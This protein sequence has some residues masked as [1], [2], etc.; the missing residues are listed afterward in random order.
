[1]D[2]PPIVGNYT[3]PA[4][5]V[6]QDGAKTKKASGQKIAANKKAKQSSGMSGR[7]PMIIGIAAG[8]VAVIAVIVFVIVKVAGGTGGTN[9]KGKGNALKELIEMK[10]DSSYSSDEDVFN[11]DEDYGYDVEE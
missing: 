11:I 5:P 7:L 4:Q 9:V 6:S 1:M 2:A 3:I 10:A 8:A